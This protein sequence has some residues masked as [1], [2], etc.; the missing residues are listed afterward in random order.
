MMTL[1]RLNADM[2]EDH[3]NPDLEFEV[4]ETEV[5]TG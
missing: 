5:A 1:N 2:D 4:E 3:L